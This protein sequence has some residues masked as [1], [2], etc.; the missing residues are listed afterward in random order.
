MS[1]IDKSVR[2]ADEALHQERPAIFL[3]AKN[4]IPFPLN[5]DRDHIDRSQDHCCAWREGSIVKNF[6][7][8][9]VYGSLGISYADR[10]EGLPFPFMVHVAKSSPV[11]IFDSHN[12]PIVFGEL[13]TVTD[14]LTY[15][16]AKEEAIARLDMLSYCGEEDLLA[17]YLLNF[18]K[19]KK[20]HFIGSL[21]Q[22]IN[23]VMIGE[24]EWFDFFE[25]SCIYKNKTGDQG[26]LRLGRAVSSLDVSECS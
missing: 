20:R 24:G 26:V 11:H 8:D 18:D 19:E 7:E 16:E 4:T 21:D 12:L 2:P 14:L 10:E 15:L 5:I 22:S 17:H 9:N 6:S 1:S 3:D 23:A 25:V 13:D